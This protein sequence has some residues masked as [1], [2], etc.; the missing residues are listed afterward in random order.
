LRDDE[1]GAEEE[2]GA[3]ERVEEIEEEQA[4]VDELEFEASIRVEKMMEKRRM[5]KT[6]Q[7]HQRKRVTKRRREG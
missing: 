3:M 5:K 7:S 1:E 4:D 6:R 2:R